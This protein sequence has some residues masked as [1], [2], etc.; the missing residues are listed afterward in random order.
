MPGNLEMGCAAGIREIEAGTKVADTGVASM[1]VT[2]TVVG[3]KAVLR[4]PLADSY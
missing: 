1:E 2:A 3:S 4:K